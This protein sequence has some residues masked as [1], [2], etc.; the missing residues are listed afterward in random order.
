MIRQRILYYFFILAAVL[1][2]LDGAFNLDPTMQSVKIILLLITGLAVGVLITE[3][4]EKILLSGISFILGLLIVSQLLSNLLLLTTIKIMFTNFILFVSMVLL[5]VGLER[6]V[7]LITS[8]DQET[9]YQEHKKEKQ[10]QTKKTT[11]SN[12][13]EQIWARIIL[14]AVGFTFVIL[15]T[16]LF[17][18]V[19]RFAKLFLTIDILITII[20]IVDLLF[21]YNK[22]KTFGEFIQKNI[23]DIIS[24]IPLVGMFRVLKIF[25]AIKIIKAS[26]LLKVL[27]VNKT[28]KFFSEESSFNK[29]VDEKKQKKKP[30]KD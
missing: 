3:N 30:K 11:H 18:A 9:A 4:Y 2:I 12:H 14:I 1:S 20:F 23:F 8:E 22:S 13:F 7:I 25:R 19:G 5:V 26:K 21:L 16:E 15:L 17:F 28:T 6:F 10:E 29:V 24:A 27:K